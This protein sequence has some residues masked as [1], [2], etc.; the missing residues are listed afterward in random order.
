MSHILVIANETVASET[1]LDA[2]RSEAGGVNPNQDWT[3][4]ARAATTASP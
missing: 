4:L 2:V 3:S 1:L